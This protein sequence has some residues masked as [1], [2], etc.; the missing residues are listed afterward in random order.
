MKSYTKHWAGRCTLYP[1]TYLNG[2][3]FSTLYRV[4]VI[5]WVVYFVKRLSV[6]KDNS[7]TKTL[8]TISNADFM[9]I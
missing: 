4:I 6:H 9:S 5:R 2:G 8:C 7:I 3:V 1:A